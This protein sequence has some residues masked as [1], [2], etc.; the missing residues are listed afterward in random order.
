MPL[1]PIPFTMLLATRA[2]DYAELLQ[3]CC[4]E[5]SL[6]L[7]IYI[8]VSSLAC[9]LRQGGSA[10]T[11]HIRRNTYPLPF[12]SRLHPVQN[13]VQ[14]DEH[15]VMEVTYIEYGYPTAMLIFKFNV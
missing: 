2:P 13:V 5:F 15:I 14:V 11:E 8:M 4:V 10:M 3:D 1:C 9:V 6:H 7:Q 12:S